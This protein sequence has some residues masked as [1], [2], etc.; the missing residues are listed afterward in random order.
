MNSQLKVVDASQHTPQFDITKTRK[1][2][3]YCKVRAV[4]VTEYELPLLLIERGEKSQ[5]RRQDCSEGKVLELAGQMEDQGQD[6]GICVVKTND[7]FKL[8]WGNTRLRGGCILEARGSKIANCTQGYIWA[9]FY[10]HK[11]SDLQMYQTKENN[12]HPVA[13]RATLDDNVGS[14]LEM[15]GRGDLDNGRLRYVDMNI[16]E[17]R[18]AVKKMAAKCSM[19]MNKF[20]TL[21]NSIRKKDPA[22]M[23]KMLTYDKTTNMPEYF[24]ARNDYGIT[25]A[26][27]P[28]GTR[29]GTVIEAGGEKICLYFSTKSSEYGGALLGNTHWKRNINDEADKVVIVCTLNDVM[30]ANFH[31]SRAVIV[32]KI[33][34]WNPSVKGGK[35]VDRILFL[36]QTQSEQLASSKTPYVLDISF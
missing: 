36:P 29:S 4:E 24:A 16:D 23:R 6:K 8:S 17:Q 15:I 12:L 33:K 18:A 10:E 5:V 30:G 34:R 11:A 20:Q 9:S 22:T 14:M 19:P 2:Q 27:C 28:S 3:R 1:R 13:Q 7:G 31:K 26:E 25:S 32:D 35:S 21:W